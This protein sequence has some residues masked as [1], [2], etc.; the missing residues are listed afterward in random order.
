MTN[1]PA[2]TF[3][4]SGFI[5]V[6]EGDLL[7]GVF[8]DLQAAFGGNLNPSLAS[9]QGQLAT[10]EAAVLGGI[11]DLFLYFVSQVD[12]AFSTGRM[13]DAIGR[14]YYLTRRPAV[15]TVVTCVCT[16]A[17][18]TLLPG[19][20]LAQSVD[21]TIYSSVDAATIGAGGTVSVTFAA[22]VT[23][24]V[25]APANTVTKIYRTIAG[26]DTVTNPTGGTVG[27]DVEGRRE[28]EQRR[29]LSVALNAVGILPAIRASVLNVP[30]II[31]AYVDENP[32]GSSVVHRGVTIAA[33]SL[34]V[35]AVGGTDEAIAQA[36]WV[37]KNGGCNY[38][39]NTTVTIEDTSSGYVPPYPSYVVKF[40]RPTN[41]PIFMEV[42][43]TDGLDVPADALQQIQAAVSATFNGASDGVGPQIGGTVYASRFYCAIAALGPWVRLVRIYVGT[44][45]SPADDEVLVDADEFPTFDPNDLALILT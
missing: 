22:I 21:G 20:T 13:Q 23:G 12:P 15:A 5:A 42:T 31:D 40:Q 43:I 2:P 28:F 29:A 25:V 30:N 39:G 24:P 14:I 1:V 9:P 35:A 44:T 17:P 18:G 10:S 11:G 16:G 45:S 7:S 4:A 19:G 34:Y 41:V 38:T 27:R 26:W 37:K 33:H 6:P 36:I 3:D 8:A 32:T